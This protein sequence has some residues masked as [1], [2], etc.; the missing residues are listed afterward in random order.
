MHLLQGCICQFKP[1]APAGAYIHT[2][3][4]HDG[5]FVN[6]TML[7]DVD[8]VAYLQSEVIEQRFV[9]FILIS[10]IHSLVFLS[11]ITHQQVVLV[12]QINERM[13]CNPI[14]DGV[15]RDKI[16]KAI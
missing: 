13:V 4:P 10:D 6:F 14:D 7:T 12:F 9:G 11:K 8:A 5:D 1:P 15:G 16:V 2:V 3:Y